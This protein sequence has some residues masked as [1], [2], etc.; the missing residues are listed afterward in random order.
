MKPDLQPE[1]L[2]TIFSDKNKESCSRLC[3]PHRDL[4]SMSLSH[5]GIM[6]SES[7]NSLN[8]QN[9]DRFSKMFGFGIQF[10]VKLNADKSAIKFKIRFLDFRV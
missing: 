7:E 5:S 2:R 6:W 8:P 1:A 3:A 10:S 9:A 4:I